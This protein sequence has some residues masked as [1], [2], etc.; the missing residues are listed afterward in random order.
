MTDKPLLQPHEVDSLVETRVR[1]QHMVFVGDGRERL[2]WVLAG[3]ERLPWFRR[4]LRWLKQLSD[5]M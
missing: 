5:R 1:G 2:R 3:G 4:F